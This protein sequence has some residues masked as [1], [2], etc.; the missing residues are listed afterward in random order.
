MR[1]HFWS[2]YQCHL[3]FRSKYFPALSSQLR[4]FLILPPSFLSDLI[5]SHAA[6]DVVPTWV[7]VYILELVG[8]TGRTGHIL[9]EIFPEFEL[10]LKDVASIDI[11]VHHTIDGLYVVKLRLK[12][13][14]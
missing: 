8:P 14:Q 12:G 13:T 1:S 5:G 9:P 11:I 7:F 6:V 4:T 10:H 3:F 2:M